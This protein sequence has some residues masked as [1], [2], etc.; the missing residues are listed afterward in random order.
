MSNIIDACDQYV[1]ILESGFRIATDSESGNPPDGVIQYDVDGYPL[2]GF[3]VVS[4]DVRVIS[5]VWN[6][7]DEVQV[8]V[9]NIAGSITY[10]DNTYKYAVPNLQ[11]AIVIQRTDLPART[12]DLTDLLLDN[13]NIKENSGPGNV[14]GNLSATGGTAPYS[15]TEITDPDNVFQVVGTELQL[16]TDT[17]GRGGTT[18]SVVIRVTDV[19]L[20]TL[21]KNFVISFNEAPDI[22]DVDLSNDSVDDGSAPGT[23][24]GTLSTVG[25]TAPFIY[26]LPVNPG[27]SLQVVGDDLQMAVISDQQDS[28][29]EITVRSIGTCGRTFDQPFS[30][31]VNMAPL[32]DILL[33]NNTIEN[34][35][36]SSTVV[37]TLTAVGGAD[38][39]IFSVF[40]DPSN[41]FQINGDDLEMS[42]TAELSD[43]TYNVTIRATDDD[44]GIFD[45]PF[46]ITVTARAI[47]DITIS[48]DTI[49][50]GSTTGTVGTLSMVGGEPA[51]V[52]SI[53]AD[54]S[55][56]F[57]LS[58][59][60]LI[61]DNEVL[62]GNSPY[63]VTVRATDSES[64]QFDKPLSVS[65]TYNNKY[66]FYP[67]NTASG[68][69]I[70]TPNTNMSWVDGQ[71]PFSVSF[72]A[73]RSSFQ[74]MTL[75]SNTSGTGNNTEGFLMRT[76]GNGGNRYEWRMNIA[77]NNRLF[78]MLTTGEATGTWYHITFTYDGSQ[79][80]SG[81]LSYVN[82]VSTPLSVSTNTLSG[83]V[84]NS[85]IFGIMARSNGAQSSNGNAFIDQF[86]VTDKVLSPAEVT[87][88][89]NSGSDIDATTLSFYNNIQRSYDFEKATNDNSPQEEDATLING[90]GTEYSTDI[91]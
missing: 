41:K 7:E 6:G 49:P 10:S 58:G 40:S 68:Q 38:P 85:N 37:G 11:R 22:T 53:I 9:T 80:G 12:P 69:Y 62:I 1:N 87:E 84:N 16:S 26:S 43:G 19:N 29:Y 71:T 51:V 59:A 54:P 33:S 86:I 36:P 57:D 35:A 91:P 81:V 17:D 67:N 72:W 48:N 3:Y 44:L 28:P 89:Y 34:Q 65:V 60:D 77:T 39:V 8:I 46:I 20:K 82:G 31:T 88:L 76:D 27:G 4:G 70:T 14:V 83:A 79:A 78:C 5:C 24:V 30:I 47:T 64:Q 23:S 66:S 25:G 21:D 50:N 15:F 13:D 63:S 73:K 42:D 61:I 56:V 32:S 18:S 75:F 74:S 2:R 90:D 52:W 55:G 45:K